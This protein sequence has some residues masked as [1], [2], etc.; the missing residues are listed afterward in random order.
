[1]LLKIVM[2]TLPPKLSNSS[3]FLQPGRLLPPDSSPLCRATNPRPAS[4]TTIEAINIYTDGSLPAAVTTDTSGI[5]R[6]AVVLKAGF[7]SSEL[8]PLCDYAS[9]NFGVACF[10]TLTRTS[11]GFVA[12]VIVQFSSRPQHL[13]SVGGEAA[14]LVHMDHHPQRYHRKIVRQKYCSS[15]S[16]YGCFCLPCQHIHDTPVAIYKM[17]LFHC[18][19][20]ER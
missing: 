13:Q 17:V 6:Y 1:M 12:E 9:K 8:G 5:A 20:T 14:Q 16:W 7:N 11:T 18:R 4:E 3:T 15:S 2:L 19:S 10:Q